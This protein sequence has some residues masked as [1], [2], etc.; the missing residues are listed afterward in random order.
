MFYIY[1]EKTFYAIYTFY[2]SRYN[3][4]SKSLSFTVPR[5]WLRS[6]KFSSTC[7]FSLTLVFLFIIAGINEG[8]TVDIAFFYSSFWGFV[9]WSN[10]SFKRSSF[11]FISF[12]KQHFLFSCYLRIIWAFP[13]LRLHS[14]HVKGENIILSD[15]TTDFSLLSHT[16]WIIP[17]KREFMIRFLS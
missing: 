7:T 6:Q 12:R 3:T 11:I 14:P 2:R 5:F 4:G 13:F 10:F 1:S 16:S 15:G 9:N 8:I 17:I